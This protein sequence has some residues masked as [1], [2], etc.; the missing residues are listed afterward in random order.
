MKKLS[1]IVLSAAFAMVAAQALAQTAAPAP[2]AD[3]S[4]TAAAS[5]RPLGPLPVVIKDFKAARELELERNKFQVV[6]LQKYQK[7]VEASKA[8]AE[9][10]DCKAARMDALEANV[11][12]LTAKGK[13][14]A[15]YNLGIKP[16]TEKPGV[17]APPIK[18]I[19]PAPVKK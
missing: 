16:G 15:A 6:T 3:T 18:A 4:P 12:A 1:T 10:V 5:P 17:P 7:C 2:A 8:A 19:L 9:L 11:A 13:F 14:D